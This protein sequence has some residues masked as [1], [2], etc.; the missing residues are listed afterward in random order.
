[1]RILQLIDSLEAGGAEKMAVNY[2]NSLLDYFSFSSLVVSRKEGLLKEQLKKEVAYLF[3]KKKA[4][5]DLMAILKLRAFV[6]QN[7][8]DLIHA[9]GTSFFLAFLVKMTMPRLKI[10]WHDHYGNSE[11]LEKRKTLAIKFCSLFFYGILSVN[12]KLEAWA[13]NKLYAKRIVYLPNFVSFEDSEESQTV[14]KGEAGKR[15]ICLAN[16]RPQKNHFL[17]LE[18]AKKI[19]AKFPDWSFHMVGKDFNDAYSKEIKKMVSAGLS[20]TVF[21]YDSRK[22]IQNILQQSEIA[23][24][25]SSSEGLP[26]ALLEYGYYQKAVV[27]TD[28]GQ[29]SAVITD[30][31]NGFLVDSSDE[32]AFCAKLELLLTDALLREQFGKAL[33]STIDER[34]T[35]AAILDRYLKFIM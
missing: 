34:H 9:H 26:V 6:K 14:L 17:L 22:D 1:M 28:V 19:K 30:H 8:I 29:I 4:A 25:T 5:F 13:R 23:V 7:R 18:V 27:A 10:I 31:A 2:A 33:K 21:L 11:F 16:L 3:L 32:I 20:E 15:I 35:A 12:T 24:L